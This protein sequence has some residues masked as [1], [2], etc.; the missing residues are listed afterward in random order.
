MISKKPDTKTHTLWLPLLQQAELVH[1][2]KSET[3]LLKERRCQKLSGVM[4]VP[5][6]L[7]GVGVTWIRMFVI[8]T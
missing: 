7:I 6:I 4:E 1:S 2:D 5:H 3:V 8:T